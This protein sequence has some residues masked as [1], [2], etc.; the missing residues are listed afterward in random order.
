MEDFLQQIEKAL[1]YNL[2]YLALQAVLTLPDICSSLL[3]PTPENRPVTKEY[4]DWCNKNF[5]SKE[6]ISSEDCYYFRCSMLHEG[7]TQHSRSNYKR[8]MFIEPGHPFSNMLNNISFQM[9]DTDKPSIDINLNTFC[10]DMISSVRKWWSA[11]QDEPVVQDNYKNM[12]KRYPNGLPPY[13]V[14]IPIIS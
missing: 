1:E 6:K 9:N 11:H 12:V 14:G 2:Y 10:S 13:I 3:S 7:Q 5:S 4:I 8:I